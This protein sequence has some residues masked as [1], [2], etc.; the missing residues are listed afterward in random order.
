MLRFVATRL[1]SA[2]TTL[3]V[4]SIVAFA[5]FNLLPGDLAASLAG[6]G[7]S[8]ESIAAIRTNLGLDGGLV[9]RYLD[10]LGNLLTGDLGISLIS[11]V[12]VSELF[13][14]RL[15]VTLQLIAASILVALVASG[16][17]ALGALRPGS[18]LDR[19]AVVWSVVWLSVPVFWVGLLLVLV[20]A[21]NWQLLPASG[22]V[23]FF[24]SPVEA[25]RFALLPAITLGFYMSAI[26]TQ[27][28]RTSIVDVMQEDYIRTAQAK[29]LPMRKVVL[30]HAAKPSLLPFLTV[31]GILLGTAVGGTILVEAVFNYPGFGRLFTESILKRDPF[32]VQNGMLLI[33]ASVIVVNF[34]VDL[35]YGVLD[36]RVRLGDRT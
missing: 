7:A 9:E 10:W 20:V 6:Q 28:L 2:V 24:D 31:L 29:G 30:Y 35:V 22:Y 13:A 1:A 12:P 15:P 3:F 19:I 21:V 5:T 26:L 25:V 33:I 8:P 16:T 11:N 18:L 17:L 23:S 4:G 27:F 14:Q 36:P 34:F 32:I